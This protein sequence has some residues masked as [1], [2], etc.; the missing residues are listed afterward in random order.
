MTRIG[1]SKHEGV[2]RHTLDA[3]RPVGFG[4][5]PSVLHVEV[6]IVRTAQHRTPTET[7]ADFKT[8]WSHTSL[9]HHLDDSCQPESYVI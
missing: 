4:P 3:A 6:V 7:T 9:T 8:L 1:V 5:H 2:E